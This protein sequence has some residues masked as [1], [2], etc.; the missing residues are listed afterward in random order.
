MKKQKIL[1]IFQ[2]F[3]IFYS[4]ERIFDKQNEYNNKRKVF[5]EKREHK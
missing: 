4:K 1:E 3:F 5:K 2:D